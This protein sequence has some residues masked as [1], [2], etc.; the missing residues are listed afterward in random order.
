MDFQG[1]PPGRHGEAQRRAGSQIVRP[2]GPA[3]RDD[4]LHINRRRLFVGLHPGLDGH[5]AA[6][7]G[8]PQPAIPGL[9]TGRL[10]DAV[11]LHGRQPVGPAERGA[12]NGLARGK[13]LQLLLAHPEDALAA[14]HPEIAEV[15]FEDLV[16]LVAEQS[17]P[18]G[19]GG[20]LA[21]FVTIE[22]AGPGADPERALAVLVERVDRVAREALAHREV[23]KLPALPTA[24]SAVRP[25]P[26]VAFVVF[27]ERLH[28]VAGQ[29]VGGGVGGEFAALKS[30]QSPA[31]ADP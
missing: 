21:A 8:E 6:D 17:L 23:G 28:G 7:R 24:Q 4:F 15:V 9:P 12:V 10:G 18:S 26:H 1:A 19:V 22:A 29:P 16:N 11:A 31:G 3:I 20:E 13:I 25:D 2:Q 27:Q 14:A 5:D 30:I